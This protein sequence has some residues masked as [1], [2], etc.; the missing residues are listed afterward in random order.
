[1]TH[2]DLP[3]RAE[4]LL[5]GAP[6]TSRRRSWAAS[7]ALAAALAL[8]AIAAPAAL[9]AGTGSWT[10]I[11]SM[12]TMRD[13]HAATLLADGRVLEVGSSSSTYLGHY[14]EAYNPAT[15]T[16]QT[17]VP[18][19]FAYFDQT[20]DQLGNGKVLI[21]GGRFDQLHGTERAQ[22]LDVTT[23][24]LVDTGFLNVIRFNHASV[25][26]SD[27]RVLVAGGE[28]DSRGI[29]L[30]SGS[31]AEIYN[32]AT[33]SWTK[34]AALSV[35]RPRPTAALLPDGRVL[36]VGS[37]YSSVA[38]TAE[39]YDPV[40]NTWTATGALPNHTG[41]VN[42]AMTVLADGRVLAVGG[43]M[44]TD[45]YADTAIY[46]PSTNQ[47][48]AAAPMANGR[49]FH[50][51]TLLQDGRVLV[52]GGT[53]VNVNWSS[54][55]YAPSTNTWVAGP[56]L[57]RRR[58]LHTAVAMADG[59]VLVAGTTL[60]TDADRAS[61]EVF[62]S[63][64][65]AV[66]PAAWNL[67]VRAFVQARTDRATLTWNAQPNTATYWVWFN[68]TLV[69]STTKTTFTHNTG[70]KGHLTGSCQVCGNAPTCATITAAW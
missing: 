21:A 58:D 42:H 22:L 17:L 2:L 37:P 6:P 46:T 41:G 12:G 3:A 30:G 65:V 64:G 9:A 32:P 61:A 70:L 1:M 36:V 53:Q 59:R 43:S 31:T 54:E 20:I 63:A 51:A 45:G 68:G 15:G 48:Q 5:A 57:N 19:A 27:G 8:G 47:W 62:Y 44:D 24:A 49:S 7:A 66:P 28:G 10:Q 4:G 18:D 26:L 40:A 11:A 14:A 50:T 33:A 35:N 23:G 25:R 55:I 60:A 39:V 34:V 69:G 52:V 38:G 67:T 16:W 29:G 13:Y 56:T